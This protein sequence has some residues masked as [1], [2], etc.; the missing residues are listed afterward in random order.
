M[1]WS[2]LQPLKKLWPGKWQGLLDKI[3]W[4]ALLQSP[5]FIGLAVIILVLALYKRMYRF[6]A[7][8]FCGSAFYFVWSHIIDKGGGAM[9]TKNV[10]S[11]IGLSVVIIAITVYFLFI[12]S[13]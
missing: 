10:I 13:D 1:D 6:L 11:F 2:F 8:V 3:D 4:P 12:R 9:T 7:I 5:Y